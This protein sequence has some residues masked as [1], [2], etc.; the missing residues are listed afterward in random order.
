MP[1]AVREAAGDR[2]MLPHRQGI[3]KGFVKEVA[4]EMGHER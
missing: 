2:E 3:W 1:N 4:F